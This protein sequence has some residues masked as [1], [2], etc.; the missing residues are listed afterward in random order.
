MVQLV[1]SDVQKGAVCFRDAIPLGGIGGTFSSEGWSSPNACDVRKQNVTA[2]TQCPAM[3]DFS[4]EIAFLMVY[5]RGRPGQGQRRD[6]ERL[7]MGL[8]LRNHSV[9]ADSD[10]AAGSIRN[11]SL[12]RM[13]FF[14]SG[15][16]AQ[17]T[18]QIV[19]VFGKGRTAFTG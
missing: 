19:D 15:V 18:V 9:A 2:K 4:A 8:R 16:A 5:S 11:L 13:V 3:D 7:V 6:S 1:E 12:L 10:R 17:P 14:S